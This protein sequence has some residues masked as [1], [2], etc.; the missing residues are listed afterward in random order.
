MV[1]LS[2][3]PNSVRVVFDTNDSSKRSQFAYDAMNKYR[4]GIDI[5]GP[6]VMVFE[7]EVYKLIVYAKG[8][9]RS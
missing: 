4:V 2:S 6:S 1:S 5:R 7:S 8:G 9:N 3:I